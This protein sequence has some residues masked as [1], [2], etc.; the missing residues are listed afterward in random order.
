MIRPAAFRWDG[1][2]M[3]PL[4]PHLA[5][6]QY[7][8]GMVYRLVPMEERSEASHRAFFAAVNDAWR[9]LPEAMAD[10]FPSADH[11]RKWALIR[12]GYRNERSIVTGSK[13][14]A[15]RV[16]AF[17]E[18]MDEFAIVTASGPVVTVWTAKSQS[19]RAMGKVQFQKS[20]G[21]VLDLLAGM[22]GTDAAALQGNAERA[23]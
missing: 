3:V 17:I 13:A 7:V 6:R 18:P 19:M 20:K 10:Q 5:D 1:D 11:L 2:A 15:E 4:N 9:N 16:A 23:A 21:D 22:I 8:V 14:E 12:T